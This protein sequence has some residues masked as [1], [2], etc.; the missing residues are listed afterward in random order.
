VAKQD[1]VFVCVEK[2]PPYAV[3]IYALDQA[4]IDLGRME[5][6]R[7]L[8]LVRQCEESGIWPAFGD[9]VTTIG[10]PAWMQKQAEALT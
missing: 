1:F 9:E 2:A 3:A 7:D 6:Q 5:Y 4:A 10:L 8:L